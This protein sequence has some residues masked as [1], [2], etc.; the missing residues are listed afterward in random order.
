MD[1][2]KWMD[3]QTIDVCDMLIHNGWMDGWIDGWMDG[4]TKGKCTSEL[5]DGQVAEFIDGQTDECYFI[6][7]CNLLYCILVVLKLYIMDV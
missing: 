2:Y 7:Y 6:T 1:I 3:S 4:L 5:T